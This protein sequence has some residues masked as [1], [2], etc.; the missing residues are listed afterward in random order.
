[1]TLG[2]IRAPP[3]SAGGPGGDTAAV[4]DFPAL[5]V[6]DDLTDREYELID[7]SRRGTVLIVSDLPVDQL[8]GGKD[9][10]HEV[11]AGLLRELLLGRHGPLDPRGVRLIGARIT[12]PLD[13]SHVSTTSGLLLDRC[14]LQA[15]T[16]QNAHVPWLSLPRSQIVALVADNLKVDGRLHLEAARIT[17][18]GELDALRLHA[19]HIGGQLDL[20]GVEIT[21]D[22]G[23]AILAD[24]MKVE[25]MLTLR[26][27]RVTGVGDDGALR[28]LNAHIRGQLHLAG[29]VI[30]NDTGPALV[31][32]GM[33][34]D[35]A[36][37]LVAAQVSGAGEL[38][39]LRLLGVR[40]GGNL[41]LTSLEIINSTGPI[42]NLVD[43][44]VGKTVFLPT[45][46]VCSAPS[47]RTACTDP[48]IVSL[49]GF[50]FGDLGHID[51]QQWLH[52]IRHH[53][54]NY[55]PGPYHVLA[56]VE[57]AAGHEGNARRILI[58]QQQDLY[59]RAP[60]AIG[61]W[62]TRRF[63]WLWGALA[64]YGYLV[65][66]TAAALLLALLVAGGLGAWAGQIT[67]GRHH[68]A[69]RTA[70]FTAAT[71]QSCTTVELIGVGLDRG[72][73]LS[74]TGVRIR[75]DLNPD[76]EWGATFTI[77]IWIVQAA[78][79]GLATLALAGYTGMVRKTG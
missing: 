38:G 62:W 41:N 27:A 26:A 9:P 43:A 37:L 68:I 66:R 58:A 74:P 10:A 35:D 61:G 23:P 46:V 64:G 5:P 54:K 77:A 50:T 45:S 33:K 22:S 42:L 3:R 53:T 20:E 56:A 17:G 70:A 13:L 60:K 79:W 78:V 76:T 14:A 40:I 19:A 39:A 75:C 44:D 21:N 11:R 65:R 71:G 29:A 24:S 48:R 1:M 67:D 36:L 25:D 31:V 4:T 51:W 34:V 8:T 18:T 12:G 59:A 63:H 49:N 16:A 30:T 15:I 32:D 52:L 72:L 7:A 2:T 47:P 6:L 57:R 55:R 69:E 73:P 28:L